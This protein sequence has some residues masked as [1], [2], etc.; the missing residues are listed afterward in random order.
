VY[1]NFHKHSH[2]SNII[3]PDSPVSNQDYALR[4]VE[5]GHKLFCSLEHGWMGRYIEGY[6][7]AK[8]YDLKFLIGTETYIVKD[9][10]EKDA[11]NAHLILLAKNE[12]GRKSIN[13]IL[14]E[15]NI[16][17]FYY[18]AR[19]DFDLLFSL[20]QDDIWLTSACLGGLWKYGEEADGFMLDLKAYFGTNFFLEVQN[21]N[22]ESQANLN[23]HIIDLSNRHNIP[24]IFGCDSHYIYENQAKDR[25]DYLLS[26]HV[27]Y[28]D[29]A[30]WFLDYPDDSE[31]YS[32]F[33]RQGILT[34]AQIK[35]AMENTNIFLEVE[36]YQSDVFTKAVKL[37]SIYSDK[38]QDE[39]NAIFSSLIWKQWEKEK[40]F[41]AQNRLGTYEKEIKKEEEIVIDTGM[42]DYFLLNQAVVKRGKESGGHITMTGRGSAPSFYISKLLGLT[43]IDRIDAPVKLFPERFIT[44]ERILEAGTM[45]DVDL[46]LGNPE[47]FAKAQEEVLGENHSYP[48]IAFGTLRPKA[49]WKLYARAKNVDF[50]TANKV[51]EQITEY[52]MVLKHVDEDSKDNVNVLDFITEEYRKLFTESEKYLGIIS[53]AKVHPCAYLL[54]NGNIKE[55][56]GLIKVKENLCT[57]MDGLWAENYKF[58]KNDL[59]KVSVVELIYRVYERIGVTPHPLPELIKLCER[60]KKVWDIYGNAWTMGINQVEQVSTSGRVAAYAPKNISEMSAFVAAIRPGF[61]SNYK[62]FE[63]RKP[64]SYGIPSLDEI[65]QTKEFPQ[66]YLIYQ[67]NAMQVM[68]YAGIPISETYE[69]VKNIAKKRAEKVLKYKQIFIEGMTK[70]IIR[71]ENKSKEEAENVAN[72]T[73]QII[74]DSARYSFNASHSYCYAGDSLYGAYLK[75]HFPLEF[76]EVFLNLLEEDGDKDRLIRAKEEAQAAFRI[77]FPPYKF[78]QDNRKIV[79]SLEKNEITSSLS[80]IKGFNQTISENMWKLSQDKY[81]SFLDLLTKIEERGMMTKKIEDLIKINYFDEFGNNKKLLDF[82]IEFT[83][84]KNRYSAK[85]TEE[86]KAK[87]LEALKE[88]WESLPNN[89][90]PFYYQVETEK[91]ILGNVLVTF[92]EID[93]RYVYILELNEKFSPRAEMYCLN[94]GKRISVKV[95]KG[96]YDKNIFRG[97]D[98]L[99]IN[100]FEKKPA[101]TFKDGRFEEIK[102]EWCW[103]A[104]DYK[105]IENDKFGEII[106]V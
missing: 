7:L 4:I 88:F 78:R 34:K 27:V 42:A 2:Y 30:N 63:E 96:V 56:I 36:E 46:N 40:P 14:S 85:H 21:H 22:T 26:K 10:K 29:E 20:P 93:K 16:T 80:S 102:N 100:R 61:K 76:Y 64:F 97:G 84:G 101:V 90:L 65:I 47:V 39:K 95:Q 69:V 19:I 45:P 49:A 15:A 99:K 73:W 82:Y 50:D 52:E 72:M 6:E 11:T 33:I 3:T 41:V 51:S 91:E 81:E 57:V 9:R 59:L 86:T 62:Q 105:V 67:E 17:G 44:K 43:T 68:A 13:R 106:G 74:E 79:A 8:Q 23:K 32:R 104:T 94:N 53:D 1:S 37:P 55:E 54:Y 25:D 87:R 18:R 60:D 66:S 12:N 83:A 70:K 98:I 35:T 48:M 89:R 92:P 71:A 75:S 5:L 31:A 58:L 38:T 77:N 28:E 24:I 103:W